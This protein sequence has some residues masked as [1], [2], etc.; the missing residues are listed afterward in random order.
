VSRSGRCG[1]TA[2]V[3]AVLLLAAACSGDGDAAAGSTSSTSTA[4]SS[5]VPAEGRELSWEVSLTSAQRILRQVG[6]GS[7][8]NY[9]WNELVGPTTVDG[10]PAQVQMLGN[11]D[12]ENGTGPFFGFVTL[13]FG[14]EDVLAFR[15]DG[16]ATQP[17]G[18]QGSADS[19]FRAEL[20]VIGGS[21]A[22]AAASGGRGTFTGS[23]SAELGGQVT[24]TMTATVAGL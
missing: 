21:G 12:Y 2:A 16:E 20:T 7:T 19:E 4:P 11:V 1:V 10:A 5:S 15:M 18:A 8:L 22:Y 14:P 13:E 6:P 24:G 3:T 17:A 23:R 9:G